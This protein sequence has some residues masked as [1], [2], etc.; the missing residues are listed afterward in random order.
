MRREDA[1]LLAISALSHIAGDPE[2]L[3]RFLAVTG[4]DPSELRAE[5][6]KSS[7][8]SGVLD[9]VCSDESLL[10]GFAAEQGLPPESVD[11]AR[12]LLAG[13]SGEDW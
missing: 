13:P 4:L 6:A 11:I 10:V 3:E 8:A 5:A 9:Y 12:Q 1:E 2:R 7:F